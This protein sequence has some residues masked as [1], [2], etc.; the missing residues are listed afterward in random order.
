M[1]AVR[2][3]GAGGGIVDAWPH[4]AG[5]SRDLH[6]LD[7]T[8]LYGPGSGGVA[9]YLRE[10]RAWLARHGAAR[11]TL[12]VPGPCDGVGPSGEILVRTLAV[13]RAAYRWPCDP[14]RWVREMRARQPDV[15][16]AGDPGPVGWTAWYAAR[17]LGVPLV[18]F[19]HSDVVRMVD[20]RLGAVAGA[21]VLRYAATFYRRCDVVVAPS[22][23]M[24]RRLAQWGIGDVR[25]VPL[26][27]DLDTF[28]PSR[29][30]GT[31]LRRLGIPRHRRVMVYAGRFA[32]EKN[33]DVLL[34]AFRRLGDGYHLVLAGGGRAI[35]ALPNVTHVPYLQSSQRLARLL[36]SADGLV[37]AGDQET[38]GLI[39]LEAMACGRG[40]VA[41][42]GGAAPE[43]VGPDAG[44]L[45]RPRDADA[46][47]AGVVAVCAG[48][49]DGVGARA[50]RR[51]E[52]RYSWD[53]AMRAM[54]NVYRD[55]VTTARLPTARYAA[56]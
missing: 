4:G 33:I 7:A 18:G 41:A 29:R 12:L 23:Y 13:T 2:R 52:Q 47:A 10:K 16:E 30:D 49:V 42:A 45:V 46:L 27:V 5:A 19:C 26:G 34:D 53:G 3:A 6:V 32:P 14:A 17:R 40:V 35:P 9:R 54:L 48:D 56:S 8:M 51:V 15:I 55:A 25:V 43:V 37:H 11:H 39:L 31:L 1:R 22:D 50:R 24:R 38:F 28:S 21:I 44:V 20:Q 36:A